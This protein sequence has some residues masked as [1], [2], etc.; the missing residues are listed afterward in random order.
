MQ[1][2]VRWDMGTSLFGP[3]EIDGLCLPPGND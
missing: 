3:K 1:R 2:V